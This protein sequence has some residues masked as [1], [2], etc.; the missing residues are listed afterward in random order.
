MVYIATL[1]VF[2]FFYVFYYSWSILILFYLNE[3]ILQG[4]FDEKIY[5]SASIILAIVYLILFFLAGYRAKVAT[6]CRVNSSMTM[7]ESHK[8]SS[9][10][11][12]T[13]LSFIPIIGFMFR[14]KK[15]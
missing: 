8:T 7:R 9:A 10:L 13:T 2:D 5:N 15:K 12:K 11:V 14:T 1:F 4:I 6:D 3:F